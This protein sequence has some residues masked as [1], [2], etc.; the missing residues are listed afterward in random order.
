MNLSNIFYG[1]AVIAF[2]FIALVIVLN[3][4]EK[5]FSRKK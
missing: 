5:I 3:W 2:I 1:A 4:I